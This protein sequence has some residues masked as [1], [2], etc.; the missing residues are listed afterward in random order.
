MTDTIAPN[1]RPS[2]TV[3]SRQQDNGRVMPPHIA[4]THATAI[5]VTN[6][7]AA[8]PMTYFMAQRAS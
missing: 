1:S 3:I 6:A 8:A 2:K 5:T 7:P 4:P